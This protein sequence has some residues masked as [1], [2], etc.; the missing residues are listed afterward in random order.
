MKTF[1]SI[2]SVPFKAL[3]RKNKLKFVGK[4]QIIKVAEKK[5]SAYSG[6]NRIAR[7]IELK[8]SITKINNQL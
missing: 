1:I 3:F 4:Q 8:E 2:N 6:L 7:K 5:S